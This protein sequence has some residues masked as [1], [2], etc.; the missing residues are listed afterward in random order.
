MT[1]STKAVANLLLGI[2]Q[3]RGLSIS[4]MKLQK[5]I[6]YAHGW[7]LALAQSPLIDEPIEAWPYGPVVD[8]LYHEFKRFGNKPITGLA[9]EVSL[10]NGDIELVIPALSHEDREHVEPL[11]SRILDLYGRFSAIELS[12]MTHEPGTPWDETWN[13]KKENLRHIDIDNDVIKGY[14]SQKQDKS[15]SDAKV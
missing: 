9:T 3:A 11:L 4:P 10:E 13:K 2:A 12:N 15:F 8:S 1:Y 14:F 6:Y 5:L 7:H